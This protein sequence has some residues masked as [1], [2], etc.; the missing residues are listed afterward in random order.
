[1]IGVKMQ[2][3]T[4]N[5]EGIYDVI[6]LENHIK[7]FNNWGSYPS[8]KFLHKEGYSIDYAR[9]CLYQSKYNRSISK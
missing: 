6:L 8:A 9:A 4:V 2:L 3:R 5:F 7:L 1:M